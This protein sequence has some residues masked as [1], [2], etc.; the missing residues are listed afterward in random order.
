[1]T[2]NKCSTFTLTLMVS[3]VLLLF[4]ILYRVTWYPS[5]TTHLQ[6]LL[7]GLLFQEQRVQPK[8]DIHVL[9]IGS[10]LDAKAD[11]FQIF[12]LSG[13]D[14][15]VPALHHDVIECEQDLLETF[16]FFF[17]EGAAG[18]R[19]VSNKHLFN[20][21][22]NTA[23][24]LEN[25][26]WTLGGNAYVIANRMA[27]EGMSVTLAGHIASGD[28]SLLHP[29]ITALPVH[30][31]TYQ[32]DI[33]LILE[34]GTNTTWGDYTTPRANRFIIHRDQHNPRMLALDGFMKFVQQEAPRLIVISGL[35]MLDNF[36]FEAGELEFQMQRLGEFLQVTNRDSL[37]HFEM[38]SFSDS[39]LLQLIKQHVL[40]YV[41][42]LGMNEQELCNLV[43]VLDRNEVTLITDHSPTVEDVLGRVRQLY[44]L[45]GHK[46]DKQ[47]SIGERDV[48]R[49]HVHS[50]T[51]QLVLVRLGS[52]WKKPRVAAAKAS[53]V[54]TRHTCN[55][56][57]INIEY[58]KLNMPERY[59]RSDAADTAFE[60]DMDKPVTCWI[61]EGAKICLAPL[62]VCTEIIHTCGGGDNISGAG[63]VPQL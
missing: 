17:N 1:M 50:I 16:A 7:Q 21:L 45:T 41:D 22:V 43:S 42:S 55:Q 25:T 18:E 52:A 19:Y 61:E 37:I 11:A 58:V 44:E 5:G 35:Q 49:I 51:F 46:T 56:T 48:T 39:H 23:R 14:T 38:A 63:L 53:L 9:G 30:L 54:A 62:L 60:I 59:Y 20:K 33:H 3:I 12:N 24:K 13:L 6:S 29:G 57:D 36:P 31:D 26:V 10:C 32:E 40:P 2:Q 4:S 15:P 47:L 28:R 27:L 8:S 34:Y